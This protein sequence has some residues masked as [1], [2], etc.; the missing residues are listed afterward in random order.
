MPSSDGHKLADIFRRAK[1]DTDLR[2]MIYYCPDKVIRIEGLE[3]EE[4]RALRA[5]DL[6]RLRLDDEAYEIGSRLFIELPVERVV[7]FADKSY[8]VLGEQRRR[9]VCI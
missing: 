2:V 5:G 3:G 7:A 6:S 1:D 9:V 4:A 8:D